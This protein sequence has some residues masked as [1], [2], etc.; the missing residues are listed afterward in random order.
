ML[1]SSSVRVDKR[2]RQTPAQK[3]HECFVVGNLHVQRQVQRRRQS[4]AGRFG[5]GAPTNNSERVYQ[6]IYNHSRKFENYRSIRNPFC[7]LETRSRSF[8]FFCVQTKQKHRHHRDQGA[9]K[10]ITMKMSDARRN[11]RILKLLP[12]FKVSVVDNLKFFLIKHYVA[13]ISDNV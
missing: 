1:L 12:A 2:R 5:G 7:D 10:T 13:T 4:I 8:F 3:D 6:L 11:T 9:H